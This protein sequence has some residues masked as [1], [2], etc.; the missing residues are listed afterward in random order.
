M[1]Q[2]TSSIHLTKTQT[3]VFEHLVL[4]KR[5]KQIASE[6]SLGIRT[7][8]SHRD[9]IFKA[10]N[11]HSAGSAAGFA[12]RH[13][14]IEAQNIIPRYIGGKPLNENQRRILLLVAQGNSQKMVAAQ[15]NINVKKVYDQSE[16]IAR[17][18]GLKG[19]MIDLGVAFTQL[20]YFSGLLQ[21]EQVVDTPHQVSP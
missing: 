18:L 5:I 10:M 9:A 8:G 16:S 6:M 4:G 19:E 14:M 2:D 11:V 1:K 21:P 15:L 7:V 20:A 3:R 17:K 12:L 13:R